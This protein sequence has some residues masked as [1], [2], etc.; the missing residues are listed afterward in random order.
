MHCAGVEEANARAPGV[1]TTVEVGDERDDR[2]R[3][4]AADDGPG[5]APT[6]S[7][8]ARPAGRPEP[9]V[10]PEL[11]VPDVSAAP[12]GGMRRAP[13]TRRC[14]NRR[15]HR[16]HSSKLLSADAV[17]SDARTLRAQEMHLFAYSTVL[18]GID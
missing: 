1:D 9:D 17:A 4:D 18:R 16:S 3:L 15:R 13:R 10:A 8:S 7:P 11:L 5:Q 14:E 6:P 12:D 2:L